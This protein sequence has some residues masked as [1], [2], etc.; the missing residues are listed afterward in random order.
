MVFQNYALYPHMTVRDNIAF[1]LVEYR[2]AARTRSR[3]ACRAAATMLE[4]DALLRARARA[5][6]RAGS[7]SA[8]PSAAPS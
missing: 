8:S 2:R 7:A 1:G 5:S 6:C 4:M 3:S